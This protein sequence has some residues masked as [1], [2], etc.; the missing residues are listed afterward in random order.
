[1]RI[2]LSSVKLEG[3]LVHPYKTRCYYNQNPKTR[4]VCQ[5]IDVF[6]LVWLAPLFFMVDFFRGTIRKERTSELLFRL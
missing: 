1:M 5:K 2:P 3:V 6:S 4:D